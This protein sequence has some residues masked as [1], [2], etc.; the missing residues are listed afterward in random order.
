MVCI[1]GHDSNDLLWLAAALLK[2]LRQTY[3]VQTALF[4]R[5]THTG[6]AIYLQFIKT[7]CFKVQS[8]IHTQI[9]YEERIHDENVVSTAERI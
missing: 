3:R 1:V 8:G 9:E 6:I 2:I 5:H 7:R 4:K